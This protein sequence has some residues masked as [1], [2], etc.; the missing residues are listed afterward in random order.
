M[1]DDIDL[2]RDGDEQPPE[3]HGNEAHTENFAEDGDEQPPEEHGNESHNRDFVDEEEAANASPVQSVN[4]EI[5]DVEIDEEVQ[6]HELA[7]AVHEDATLDELSQKVSD[8]DL[9]G[10][11]DAVEN[12][13]DLG[14]VTSS[15]HHSR[16]TDSEAADAAPVSSVN[17]QTG[18]VSLSVEL[19]Y[20]G[21]VH[22][23]PS[24]FTDTPSAP[25]AYLVRNNQDSI[26]FSSPDGDSIGTFITDASPSADIGFTIAHTGWTV[27][28]DTFGDF[29]G[30]LTV[31]KW[32]LSI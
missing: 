20:L 10:A 7:G 14:G 26:S 32:E 1:A 22:D 3:G 11:S 13:D 9:Q 4:G 18:S 23:E 17:E 2:A 6:V 25:S 29:D 8:D 19:N 15:Q 12:H 28:F 16:Y 31:R 27:E 24:T 5:G 21:I 30:D